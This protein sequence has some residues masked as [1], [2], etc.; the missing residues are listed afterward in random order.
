[1]CA[2]SEEYDTN[3]DIILVWSDNDDD[4]LHKNVDIGLDTNIP[5]YL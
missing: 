3:M 2:K 1:M 5:K 4:C